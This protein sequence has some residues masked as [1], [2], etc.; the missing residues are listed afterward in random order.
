ML[1]NRAQASHSPM[2]PLLGQRSATPCQTENL[3][4][5][6]SLL[7]HAKKKG[8]TVAPFY[9]P[10]RKLENSSSPSQSSTRNYPRK[11]NFSRETKPSHKPTLNATVVTLF[12]S[13]KP[14]LTQT[15]KCAEAPTPNHLK[16]NSIP[17]AEDKIKTK[18]SQNTTSSTTQL[19]HNTLPYQ[20]AS[21]KPSSVSSTTPTPNTKK[22]RKTS[23]PPL[24][25][26]APT[27]PS[28]HPLKKRNLN[29]L[30]NQNPHQCTKPKPTCADRKKKPH[31]QN[32]NQ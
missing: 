20:D 23:T 26:N 29:E 31:A 9:N 3:I 4:T 11:E 6:M 24:P 16:P 21:S 12:Q 28:P 1:K 19:K 32:A 8:S 10:K 17:Q 30:L 5:R 25:H 22:P 13:T 15:L 27:K 7:Q 14:T 2:W 18:R